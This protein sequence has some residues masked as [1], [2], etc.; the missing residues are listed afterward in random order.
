VIAAIWKNDLRHYLILLNFLALGVLVVYLIVALLSPKRAAKEGERTP[1]NQTPFLEDEDLETKRLERVQGW[2]LIFAA[3]VAVALPIYWLREPTRQD[4]STTYFDQ[5]SVDRGAVLFAAPGGENYN[6]AVSKQCANCHGAEGQGGIAPFRINGEPVNWKAPALNS[7]ILRF[8]EDPLCARPREERTPD[9][10][11][12]ITNIITYGREGTPMQGWGVAGGGP[13]NE[14]GV[15]DLVAY[16]RSFTIS[17]EEA[18]KKATADLEAARTAAQDQ[19]KAAQE[20]LTAATTALGEARTP[21]Q[22]DLTM[23][24]ADDT[25][26]EKTCT[27]LR[28]ALPENPR[29]VDETTRKQA[30]SCGE[31]LAALEDFNTA[32]A[33]YD[34]A[35]E[36]ALRRANVQDGQLLFELNCAR[37]HTKGWSIFD[38]TKPATAVDG[39]SALGLSGGGGGTGGGIGFNL[40]DGALFRRFGPDNDEKTDGFTAHQKFVTEGSLPF[41]GYGSGGLGSGKMPGFGS[42]LTEQQIEQIVAYERYC[43]DQTNY[44]GV[45]PFCDSSGKRPVAPSSSTTSSTT[46]PGG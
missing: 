31:Y 7:E 46:T 13:L 35:K 2:A 16:I 39:V 5:N 38:P 36:W 34:W 1:A 8:R 37:C 28:G 32:Q 27:D 29:D 40:R 45:T 4:Q 43:I 3:V 42:M 41:K 14:Q 10:V 18:Q 23:P 30:R 9:T 44:L 22:D 21:A 15:A 17:P 19:E 11:C 25:A 26:L 24:G 6:G 33:A 12:E 20:A